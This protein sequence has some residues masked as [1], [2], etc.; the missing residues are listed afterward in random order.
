MSICR[1]MDPHYQRCPALASRPGRSAT[2]LLEKICGLLCIVL[3]KRVL[4]LSPHDNVCEI[5]NFSASV[6]GGAH[7]AFRLMT[8]CAV[9]HCDFLFRTPPP[10][11]CRPYLTTAG[12]VSG[13]LPFVFLLGLPRRY[14]HMIKVN[15]PHVSS[16]SPCGVWGPHRRCRR[17][18]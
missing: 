2:K 1:M 12:T 18:R 5:V 7:S 8:A 15:A 9:R 16:L 10:I 6:F 11:V 3:W 17:L 4:G 14:I 13:R